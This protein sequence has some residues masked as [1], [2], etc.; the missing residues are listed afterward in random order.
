MDQV[1]DKAINVFRAKGYQ[2]TSLS[3]LA[4]A[5]GLTG[6]SLY[7]AFKAKNAVFRAAFDRY[8][9]I[10]HGQ[11]RPILEQDTSG[12]EKIRDLISLYVDSSH[13]EKGRQGCLIVGG[14]VEL[15]ML[16]AKSARCV[17]DALA[18]LEN[19]IADLIQSG[20]AD[21]SISG[22]LDVKAAARFIL[23]VLQGLRVV[24]KTGPTRQ[25][26]AAAAEIALKALG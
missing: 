20:Q 15:S 24:G 4:T 1:L 18:R 25:E 8:G 23:C 13:G 10:R 21:G 17:E 14:A 3:D 6:G 12:R 16:E 9:Y 22:T 2:G 7:K 11:L 26:T 5:T 19:L